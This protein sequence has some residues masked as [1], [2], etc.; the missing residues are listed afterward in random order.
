MQAGRSPILLKMPI[1]IF[2][3]TKIF[4]DE[5]KWRWG[6]FSS[7]LATL[8]IFDNRLAVVVSVAAINIANRQRNIF[9]HIDLS[10]AFTELPSERFL[11]FSSWTQI[12]NL[13]LN[14]FSLIGCSSKSLELLSCY[15]TK[16]GILLT[17]LL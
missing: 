10:I 7:F 3:L 8:M 5:E 12:K 2:I 4:A 13:R 6:D 14:K 16:W 15:W 17:L 9:G 1:F 11:F